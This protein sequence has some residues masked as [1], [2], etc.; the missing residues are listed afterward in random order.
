MTWAW[1]VASV[2]SPA[3]LG[4][5][6]VLGLSIG[7][8]TG[9]PQAVPSGW[10]AVLQLD[11]GQDNAGPPVANPN[12]GNVV[13]ITPVTTITAPTASEVV[14][15]ATPTVSLLLLMSGLGG[16]GMLVARGRARGVRYDGKVRGQSEIVCFA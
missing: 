5:A 16:L 1:S 10:S 15:T 14:V 2:G 11:G 6:Q 8:S 4:S 12:S 7:N 3:S 9:T 13:V